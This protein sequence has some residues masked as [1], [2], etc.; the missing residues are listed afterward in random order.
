LHA[1]CDWLAYTACNHREAYTLPG[2]NTRRIRI[3]HSD[4]YDGDESNCAPTVLQFAGR[5]R[6]TL[7]NKSVDGYKERVLA[8]EIIFK[9]LNV[10]IYDP[11]VRIL[12]DN[13]NKEDLTFVS[14]D[15]LIKVRT[16]MPVSQETSAL[17][18]KRKRE[19]MGLR[20]LDTE[21][22]QKKTKTYYWRK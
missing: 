2:W 5:I 11:I 22:R 20:G 15:D 8:Q 18:T 7:S 14:F 1:I 17:K 6:E 9:P 16:I 10:D 13:K 4:G 19:I 3:F 21:E 12:Y